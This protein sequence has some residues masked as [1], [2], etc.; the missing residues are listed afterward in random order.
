M[1]LPAML[2]AVALASGCS[3]RDTEADFPALL[4]RSEE[5]VQGEMAG[6]VRGTLV[7][8]TTRGCI[9]L[10]ERPVVW[11]ANTAVTSDPPTIHLPGGLSATTGDTIMGTGG[12]V[13]S[14]S[15]LVTDLGVEGDLTAALEC[16]PE[17][18]AVAVFTARGDRVS[19]TSS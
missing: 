11:P 18:S 9:L 10:S 1:L 12:E 17:D 16:A 2:V 13:P 5:G 3:I 4:V 15:I 19:V 7:L 14:R 8:D 6:I